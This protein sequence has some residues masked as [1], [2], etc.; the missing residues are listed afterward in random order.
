MKSRLNIVSMIIGVILIIISVC[1]GFFSSFEHKDG[2]I[3]AMLMPGFS[4]TLVGF[5]FTP[6]I[7]RVTANIVELI[8]MF[9]SRP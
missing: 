3:F 4:L 1:I 8:S 5:A 9:F 2:I 6:K 7:W